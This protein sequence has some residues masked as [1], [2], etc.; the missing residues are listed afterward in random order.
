MRRLSA[1]L[2]RSSSNILLLKKSTP[3]S[4]RCRGEDVLLVVGMEWEVTCPKPVAHKEAP[5]LLEAYA[6]DSRAISF[7]GNETIGGT[8]G[9][10]GG[11]EARGRCQAAA[12]DSIFFAK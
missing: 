6:R 9:A 12:P 4:L 7:R 2:W 8:R 10:K 5:K 3:V 1:P 11:E